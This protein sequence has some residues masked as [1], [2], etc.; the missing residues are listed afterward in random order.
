[1]SFSAKIPQW[2]LLAL[3]HHTERIV[4]YACKQSCLE[5][6]IDRTCISFSPEELCIPLNLAENRIRETE[7]VGY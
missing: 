5:R 3:F 2:M 4:F 6:D 7:S 1:M